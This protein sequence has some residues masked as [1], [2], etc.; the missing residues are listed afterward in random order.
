MD[1]SFYISSC[2]F[3][4][5]LLGFTDTGDFENRNYFVKAIAYFAVSV[6]FTPLVPIIW[7]A[8]LLGQKSREKQEKD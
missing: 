1:V 6:F 5:L 4:G 8:Y 7:V 2:V 3:A